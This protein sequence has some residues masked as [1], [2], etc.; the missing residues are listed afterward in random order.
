MASKNK[1]SK[2]EM[3]EAALWVV[4]TSELMMQSNIGGIGINEI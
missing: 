3:A 1:F 2:A 4:Q